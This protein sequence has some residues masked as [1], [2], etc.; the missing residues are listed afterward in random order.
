MLLDQLPNDRQFDL[1]V[2]GTGFGSLFFL[3]KF[4]QLK[5]DARI[6]VLEWGKHHTREWQLENGRNSEQAYT[7]SYRFPD[8]QKTWSTT[9]AL[10]GGTLCWWALTPRMFPADFRMKTLYGV[11]MDW[12]ITYD[13]LIPY[14]REAEEIMMISGPD[15]LESRFPGTAPYPMA[16][17]RFQTPDEILKAA[18]PNSHFAIPSA[19]L[20]KAHNGRGACCSSSRCNLCPVDAKFNALNEMMT[21]LEAPGTQVLTGARVL[22]V[23]ITNNVAEGVVFEYQGGE[24]AVRGDTVVLGANAIQSPFI[25]MKSGLKHPALGKYLHEKLPATVE[26]MLDGTDSFDGGQASTGINYAL[27]DAADRSKYG[28]AT[29]YTENRWVT[30]LRTE[31]GRW[32]QVLPLRLVVEDIPQAS[33]QV[34]VGDG[35]LPHVDHPDWSDYA[36]K[37]LEVAKASLEKALSALPVESV[38]FLRVENTNAHVQ[39]TLR[40]GN[41]PSSS[42]VDSNQVHHQIRNL[43]CVGT[44]VWASCAVANPSLTAA[45]LSLRAAQAA[46]GG[47]RT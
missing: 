42:I 20:R 4:Q 36:Y 29:F 43:I 30:G 3:K 31:Y 6:L 11:G 21:V 7:D 25:L 47:T 9:I 17:H 14:Y 40:M 33:N 35:D 32:R 27:Y 23:D 5:P 2:I 1:I 37:G 8:G 15:D 26:I 18:N 19:R 44:S 46:A 24:V 45:A 41:D 28:A 12:P 22:S 34:R 10:G 16:E 39:G 13:D 38:N